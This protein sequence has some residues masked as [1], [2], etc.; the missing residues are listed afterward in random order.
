MTADR[1]ATAALAAVLFVNGSPAHGQTAGNRESNPKTP[2]ELQRQSGHIWDLAMPSRVDAVRPLETKAFRRAIDDLRAGK[3]DVRRDVALS[4]G[5][6]LSGTGKPFLALSLDRLVDAD[7]APALKATLFGEVLDASGSAIAG[8]EVDDQVE[9][10]SGRSVVDAA[11]ALPV[12][13]SRVIVGIALRGQVRWLVEQPL[14]V[15]PIDAKA[16]T[17]SRPILSLDVH[18]LEKP[19]RP[20]DPFCF[21]GLRV[22][23]RGDRVFRAADQPW[24]FVVARTPGGAPGAPPALTAGLA[25]AGP[26]EGRL[27]RYPI[28]GLTPAPLRG[29]DGQWGLGIPLPVGELPPGE[30]RAELEVADRTAGTTASAEAIFTVGAPEP[31]ASRR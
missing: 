8:F 12:G 24:L 9:L 27:R 31:T 11:L 29:F 19:Q 13:A 26:E 21:G 15:V 7:L 28:S 5:E 4:W 14:D 10:A 16:F 2:A 1:I 6:F 23:P 22:V 17:L 18:P 25:I 3:G 20:D 30:Y